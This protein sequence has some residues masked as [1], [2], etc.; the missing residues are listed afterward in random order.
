MPPV[1]GTLVGQGADEVSPA[2][3]QELHALTC[4]QA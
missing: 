3:V 1:E 4:L 2:A